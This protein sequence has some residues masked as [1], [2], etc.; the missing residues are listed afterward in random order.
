MGRFEAVSEFIVGRITFPFS[1]YLLN[2]RNIVSRYQRLIQSE[3][4]PEEKLLHMQ[5]EKLKA[6]IMHAERHVPY[7]RRLF[8][9]IGLAPQDIRSLDDITA[10]PPLS[11]YDVIEHHREMVDERLLPAVAYAE[12]SGREPG[13]P[14]SFARLRRHRLVRNT[15]SGSTGAPTVFYEDGSRTAMNW[16]YELR[17]KRWYGVLPG[18]REARMVRISTDYV[19]NNKTN[20]MRQM[21]WGQLI[22]PGVNLSVQEYA[23][24]WDA[25]LQFRPK[26][27]WGFTSAIAGLADYVNSKGKLPKDYR[28]VMVNGWAAPVYEH[29]ETAMSNAFKCSVTNIYSAREVGHIAGKCPQGAFHVNQE[30]LLVESV[31]VHHQTGDAGPGELVVTN[32]D[33]TPMPF[34]RYRMGDVGD[35]RPSR[36]QCGRTL[37]VIEN[38]LGRTGEIFITKDGKMI[39]PN[40][41]C[42]TFMSGKVSG[43]VRRF[44]VVYTKT[45]DL[46][47]KVEK[48]SLFSSATETYIKEMVAKNF[49]KDTSLEIEY[50]PEIKPM[51]SGKYQMVVNEA[52]N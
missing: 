30:N 29:E 14:L 35:V 3:A 33:I 52:A 15:S 27:I 22:L 42:R 13:V 5:L 32:L 38:L 4:Y 11:R 20:K 12:A 37:Q 26:V 50:V 36:C 21:L 6:V 45:K 18:A 49:S 25:I 44:Q 7:Y 9:K 17:L 41:W 46:K 47:I 23:L 2:R 19:M 24:C 34:I 8:K 16:A 10:I 40:F 51:L 43:A 31:S 1:Q 48:D 39:S 28:P